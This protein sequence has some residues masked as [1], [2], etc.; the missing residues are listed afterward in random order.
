VEELLYALTPQNLRKKADEVFSL[1]DL[2]TLNQERA[3]WDVSRFREREYF[4]K[5]QNEASPLL[6][7]YV[8]LYQE[9]EASEVSSSLKLSPETWLFLYPF[10]ILPPQVLE[11]RAE[12]IIKKIEVPSLFYTAIFEL[13]TLCDYCEV[14]NQVNVI[15]ENLTEDKSPEFVVLV[16]GKKVY[17]ECKALEDK[18]FTHRRVC[19]DI[20]KRIIKYTTKKRVSC[21]IKV[22]T[23]HEIDF[24][25]GEAIAKQL[26]EKIKKSSQVDEVMNCEG[27]SISYR[28]MS[29]P[30][31]N[32][33]PSG[34]GFDIFVD[35]KEGTQLE[36]Q[37]LRDKKGNLRALSAMFI[38][39]E[40]LKDLE[41]KLITRLRDASKQIPSDEQGV[42]HILIPYTKGK[43]LHSIIDALFNKVFSWLKRHPHLNA[44]I[45]TGRYFD[46]NIQ[47]LDRNQV[48]KYHSA[49]IPNSEPNGSL[50]EG[51]SIPYLQDVS[52][53]VFSTL[54][55]GQLKFTL[56]AQ[57]SAKENL[58]RTIYYEATKDGSKQIRVFVT[59]DALV[60]IELI[61]TEFGRR[62]YEAEG[63]NVSISKPETFSF[64]WDAKNM[65]LMY[66]SQLHQLKVIGT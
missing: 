21:E 37:M 1:F 26:I 51:F 53:C 54:L 32:V 34:T 29:L 28:A 65:E 7:A 41:S 8:G 56:L 5:F 24:K 58:G 3:K 31:F 52:S 10:L 17:V 38:E 12:H 48:I 63:M 22:S 39:T 19:S 47:N 57:S 43:D 62:L 20:L 16:N 18:N 15:D 27:C 42:V 14:Y 30:P 46:P 59:F 49:V 23:L 60:R 55:E 4:D 9:V 25:V 61:S 40:G 66:G 2:K 33:V 64:V 13:R 50:P 45:L 35:S 6:Q 11:G 44:V 36:T